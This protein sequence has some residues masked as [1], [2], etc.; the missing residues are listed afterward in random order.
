MEDVIPMEIEKMS[1]RKAN[2]F[3]E[4]NKGN[5]IIEEI[6]LL[7]EKRMVAAFT[8]IVIKQTITSGYNRRL[9][10]REL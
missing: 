10:P 1:W 3:L 4:E 6:H 2:P 7:E 5:T 9:R 8:S